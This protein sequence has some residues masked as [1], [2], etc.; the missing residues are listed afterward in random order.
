MQSSQFFLQYTRRGVQC[1]DFWI[2]IQFRLPHW[3]R[4]DSIALR[5]DISMYERNN[6]SQS[7]CEFKFTEFLSFATVSIC[8]VRSPLLGFLSGF[9]FHIISFLNSDF[10]ITGASSSDQTAV[11]QS[12][13]CASATSAYELANASFFE[14]KFVIHLL[15]TISCLE[16][17]FAL[18]FNFFACIE[19]EL[20]WLEKSPHCTPLY[21]RL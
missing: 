3:N 8:F 16:L 11:S 2:E 6:I 12:N 4:I 18:K 17:K 14:R 20:N 19:L 5:I 15:K 1:I 9:S 7:D 13:P 10:Y 21:T